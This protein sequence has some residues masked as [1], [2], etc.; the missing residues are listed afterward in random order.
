[1]PGHEALRALILGI[2]QGLT[3]FLP[4]SSSGHLL[5]FPWVLGWT[6]SE[7]SF[8][9]V[10]HAGTL[11]AVLI[12]FWQ[13]WKRVIASFFRVDL[14]GTSLGWTPDWTVLAIATIPALI[15]GGLLHGFIERTLR[16]PLFAIADLAL[17]GLLLGY[18]D[19]RAADPADWSGVTRKQALWIGLAQALALAPGV[20]RSGICMTAALLLR[21]PR[22]EAARFSFLMAGPVIAAAAAAG[23]WEIVTDPQTVITPLPLL[24]GAAAAFITGWLCIGLLLRFLRRGTLM[25]FAVYRV[26]LAAAL[27]VLWFRQG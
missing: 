15:V 13:D 21:V 25:P 5:L 20:S 2:V 27:L 9:I 19:R 4:V 11:F 17:F 1:M 12:Y 7:L 22:A 6:P 8:D 14:R 10:L 18:A 3:E 26:L 16:S 24:V 23:L